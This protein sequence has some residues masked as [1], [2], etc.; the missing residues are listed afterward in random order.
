MV[1]TF[2]R[3]AK[4]FDIYQGTQPINQSILAGQSPGKSSGDLKSGLSG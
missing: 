1:E 3:E 4:I 2:A